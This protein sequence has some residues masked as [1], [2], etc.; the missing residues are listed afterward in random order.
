MLLEQSYQVEVLALFIE[1]F[2]ER[3]RQGQPTWDLLIPMLPRESRREPCPF[4]AGVMVV[5]MITPH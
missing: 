4:D 3:G 1:R 2:E 5:S